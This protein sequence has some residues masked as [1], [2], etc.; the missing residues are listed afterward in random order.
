MITEI[1]SIKAKCDMFISS[2]SYHSKTVNGHSENVYRVCDAVK[3]LK[4]R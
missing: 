2:A 3:I 4:I 1:G